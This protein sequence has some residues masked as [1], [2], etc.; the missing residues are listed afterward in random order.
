VVVIHA[1]S[2]FARP[3]PQDGLRINRAARRATSIA[4]DRKRAKGRPENRVH[5]NARYV[6]LTDEGMASQVRADDAL[7]V[8]PGRFRADPPVL[9]V[10]PKSSRV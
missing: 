10:A 6:K 2:V 9:R 4:R 7:L 3:C 1:P 8:P 5:D